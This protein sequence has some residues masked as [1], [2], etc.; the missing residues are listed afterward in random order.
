MKVKNYNTTIPHWYNVYD[1]YKSVS[2]IGI[3]N[4]NMASGRD[5][6]RFRFS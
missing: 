5:I 2:D 6:A 3:N 1:S 4:A